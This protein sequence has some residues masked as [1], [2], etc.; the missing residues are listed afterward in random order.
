MKG[1]TTGD[2]ERAPWDPSVLRQNKPLKDV[3]SALNSV[4]MPNM[5]LP[6]EVHDKYNKWGKDGYP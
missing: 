2:E 6:K 1:S 3:P 4:V 5:T